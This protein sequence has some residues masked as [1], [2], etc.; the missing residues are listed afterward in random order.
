MTIS[1]GPFRRDKSITV[2]YQEKSTLDRITLLNPESHGRRDEAHRRR[3]RSIAPNLFFC[4]RSSAA[5]GI[6]PSTSLSRF[7]P[8]NRDLVR[9]NRVARAW[10]NIFK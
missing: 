4:S 6:A 9:R 1:D 2:Y 8:N 7:S 3:L 5:R 10:R